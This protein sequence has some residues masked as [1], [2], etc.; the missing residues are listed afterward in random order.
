[1]TTTSTANE[2]QYA[3]KRKFNMVFDI[4][5]KCK[6]GVNFHFQNDVQNYIDYSN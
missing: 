1:M 2:K 5:L 4:N 3:R 6:L